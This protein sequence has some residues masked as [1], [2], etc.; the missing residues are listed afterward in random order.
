MR[1]RPHA[2]HNHSISSQAWLTASAPTST[3]QR[4][5]TEP[6][7]IPSDLPPTNGRQWGQSQPQGANLRVTQQPT[8]QGQ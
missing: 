2:L 4:I 3:D 7:H 8:I 6:N 5:S 1:L